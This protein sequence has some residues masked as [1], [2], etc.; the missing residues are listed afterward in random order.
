IALID[1]RIRD[2][3]YALRG[4]KRAPLVAFTIVSTVAL[5]LGLVAAVFTVLNA[6]VFRVDAVPDV[7][8]LFAVDRPYGDE[9]LRF[10]RDEF[11]AFRRETSV[12]SETYAQLNEVDARVDGRLAYGTF[13]TGNFFQV[14]RVGAAMGRTLTPADEEPSG[15]QRVVVLSHNGWD[16]LFARDPAVLGRHLNINSLT[17]DI[18][19]VIPESFP[20]LAVFWP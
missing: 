7:H 10:T 15:G 6:L 2:I 1:T 20:G 12:F 13:V 3:L 16:R 5:G 17:F 18:V 14:L 9:P 11:D 8:E 19:G 4:V